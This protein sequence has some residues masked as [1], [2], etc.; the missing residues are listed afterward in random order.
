MGSGIRTDQALSSVAAT[1]AH[2]VLDAPAGDIKRIVDGGN[3]VALVV[4]GGAGVVE[5]GSNIVQL[6]FV[7]HDHILAG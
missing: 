4:A 5:C 6:R 7:A 1:L 2:R 3:R